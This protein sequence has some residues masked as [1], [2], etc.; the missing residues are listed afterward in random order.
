MDIKLFETNIKELKESVLIKLK[1]DYNESTLFKN[2]IM[3]V[4]NERFF[5]LRFTKEIISAIDSFDDYFAEKNKTT[6]KPISHFIT[7]ISPLN[8]KPFFDYIFYPII[9]NDNLKINLRV[10]NIKENSV[11]EKK[12][13]EILDVFV[14]YVNSDE[15]KF[16]MLDQLKE[17]YAEN[18]DKSFELLQEYIENSKEFTEEEIIDVLSYNLLGIEFYGEY[19]ENSKE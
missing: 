8:G 4:F 9:D 1:T 14:D 11:L 15:L 10:F 13:N 5:G 18:I 2:I 17:I 3:Q 7:S 12:I 19:Y 16:R 6:L